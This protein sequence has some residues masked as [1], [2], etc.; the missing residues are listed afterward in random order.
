M[1]SI[2]YGDITPVS[3]YERLLT[4]LCMILSSMTFAFI[5]SD[6]GK[7]VGSYNILADQFRERML[8]VE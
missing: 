5:I 3:T 4:M 7:V 2:G 8:Y 1:T 6:I